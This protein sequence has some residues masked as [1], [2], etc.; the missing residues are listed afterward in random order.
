ML[1]DDTRL[2][3]IAYLR[4]LA[5]NGET[6][7]QNEDASSGGSTNF[8]GSSGSINRNGSCVSLSSPDVSFMGS[9][10]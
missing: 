8:F 5:E 9:G 6:A 3:V 2:K 1:D 4:N 10:C 7:A